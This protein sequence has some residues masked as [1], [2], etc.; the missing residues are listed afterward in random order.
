MPKEFAVSWVFEASGGFSLST[1]YTEKS[2]FIRVN[3]GQGSCSPRNC[4]MQ[5]LFAERLCKLNMVCQLL[6]VCFPCRNLLILLILTGAAST[7][8]LK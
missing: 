1:L 8:P 4:E 5:P 6:D 3:L 7:D 2:R